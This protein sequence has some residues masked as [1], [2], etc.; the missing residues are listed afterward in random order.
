MSRVF[1]NYRRLDSAAYAGRLYDR[2]THDLGRDFVFMDIDKIDPDDD[3]IEV[4]EQRLEVCKAVIVLIGPTWVDCRDETGERRLD[5]PDDHVRRE[6]AVALERQVRV[7][8][9][10]VGGANMPRSDRLPADLV[11]LVRRNAIELSDQRFHHDVDRLVEVLRR[12]QTDAEEARAQTPIPQPPVQDKSP[13]ADDTAHKGSARPAVTPPTPTESPATRA[14]PTP[15]IK[16]SAGERPSVSLM[17]LPDLR[18]HQ[19]PVM[20]VAF[21]PDGTLLASAGGGEFFGSDTAIRLWNLH[22][23]KLLREISG[24]K[25]Y[26]TGLAF[27]PD[28]NTLASCSLEALRFWRVSDG[29]RQLTIEED[30]G[31]NVEYSH[32]GTLL[33]SGNGLYQLP[34]GDLVRTL[35]GDENTCF[36]LWPDNRHFVGMDSKRWRKCRIDDGQAVLDVPLAPEIKYPDLALS[37]NGKLLAAGWH[38][39]DK[40]WLTLFDAD[41]GKRLWRVETGSGVKTLR[42]HPQYSLLV[43]SN[44]SGEELVLWHVANGEIAAQTKMPDLTLS[45]NEVHCIAFSPDGKR[46]AAACHDA[47][48]RQWAIKSRLAPG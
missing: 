9:V 46:I 31:E 26:V 37:V 21:S 35:E 22:D 28:G 29:K 15:P 16:D 11:R 45:F 34:A 10:L 38:Q 6:L 3:W 32:D 7:I 18:A 12:E 41:S 20:C 43:G 24:H 47:V 48:V 8:P 23:G 27:S 36:A 14:A 33:L 13:S 42:F 4:I 17:P 30:F 19:K 1:I 44:G 39:S 40:N 2:L 5:N 25:D